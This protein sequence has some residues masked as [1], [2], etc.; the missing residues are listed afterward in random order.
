MMKNKKIES[1]IS[2]GIP[3]HNNGI[4][5]WALTR[6][7]AIVVLDKFAYENIAVYGG[8]IFHLVNNTLKHSYDSWYCDREENEPYKD[9]CVRSIGVAQNYIAK[10]PFTAKKETFV[11]FTAD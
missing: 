2:C 1:I 11:V 4:N 3:L 5:N 10:Y 8:D 9:F 6:A 7:Q